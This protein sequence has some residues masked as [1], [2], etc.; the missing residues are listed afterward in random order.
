MFP[1]FPVEFSSDLFQFAACQ[2][3]PSRDN[4][5]EASYLRTQQRDVLVRGEIHFFCLSAGSVITVIL[6]A[7]S[8]S[9]NGTSINSSADRFA[10]V[11]K[12]F[13]ETVL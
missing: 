7:D 13:E 8:V 4:R 12:F 5:R 10:D 1:S 6:S 2:I 3:P 11:I 9:T